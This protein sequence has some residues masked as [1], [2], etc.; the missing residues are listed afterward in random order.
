MTVTAIDSNILIDILEGSAEFGPASLAALR[1][2]RA[3]GIAVICDLV[4][5]EVCTAFETR[6]MCDRF[7]GQFQIRSEA[8]NSTSSFI[9]SRSWIEYLRSGGKRLRVLPDFLIAAHASNQADRLLTRDR[10]FF[11]SHFPKLR[12]MDPIGA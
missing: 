2:A 9:A 12:I 7:L 5:A 11:R 3:Q 10:G 1:R 8:L 6:E 4:Y